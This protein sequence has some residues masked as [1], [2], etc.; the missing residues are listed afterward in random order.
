MRRMKVN[1]FEQALV[2]LNVAPSIEEAVLDWMLAHRNVSGFTSQPVFGH[3]S[4]HEGL[5][6][7]EQVSG[8]QRRTEFQVQMPAASVDIFLTSVR[9]KFAAANVHFWVIPVGTCGRL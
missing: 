8:R 1:D 7:A 2:I 9:E 4:R 5:S 3:S 6:L